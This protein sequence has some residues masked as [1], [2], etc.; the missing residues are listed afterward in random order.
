[1]LKIEQIEWNIKIPNAL[2]FTKIGIFNMLNMYKPN[3]LINIP[4]LINILII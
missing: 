4:S 2:V 1:M 3:I